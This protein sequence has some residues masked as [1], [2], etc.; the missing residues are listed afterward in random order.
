MVTLKAR[1]EI[2]I[3][4]VLECLVDT[5]IQRCFHIFVI[6]IFINIF[7]LNQNFLKKELFIELCQRTFMIP[8]SFPL[9]K[10]KCTLKILVDRL[11]SLLRN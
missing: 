8:I 4:L 3:V 11:M 2:E 6:E 1:H 9:R 10:K 7:F 5:P